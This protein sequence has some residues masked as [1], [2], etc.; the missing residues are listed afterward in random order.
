MEYLIIWVG[1]YF[2]NEII[3]SIEIEKSITE[4]YFCLCLDDSLKIWIISIIKLSLYFIL[5]PIIYI[6][7]LYNWFER[8]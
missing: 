3:L 1:L 4:Q 5:T 6:Y 7:I 2:F 8:H